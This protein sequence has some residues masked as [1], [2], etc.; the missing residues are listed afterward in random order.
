MNS[1]ALTN[2]AC[3]NVDVNIVCNFISDKMMLN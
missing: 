2:Q 3:C 1:F